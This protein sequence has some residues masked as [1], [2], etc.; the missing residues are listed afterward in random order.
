LQQWRRL[1][2]FSILMKIMLD[3][4]FV[5]LVIEKVILSALIASKIINF[6]MLPLYKVEI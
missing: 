5:N 4:S 3:V 1:A 6:K 2:D